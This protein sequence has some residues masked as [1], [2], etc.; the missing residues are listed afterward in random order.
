MTYVRVSLASN[1]L[2]VCPIVGL[3]ATSQHVVPIFLS[4]LKD[5]DRDVRIHLF[6]RVADLNQ[7]IPISDN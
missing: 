3:E 4:L 6:K 1:L 2:S 7:V 5:E